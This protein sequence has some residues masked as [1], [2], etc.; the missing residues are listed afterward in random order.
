MLL[1]ND[2]F[3]YGKPAVPKPSPEV[4]AEAHDMLADF[5]TDHDWDAAVEFVVNAG[6]SKASTLPRNDWYRLRRSLEILKV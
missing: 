1:V 5:Q 6:D 3:I 4:I 2:R